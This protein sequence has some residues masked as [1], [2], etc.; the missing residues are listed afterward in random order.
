MEQVARQIN[1]KHVTAAATQKLLV[2]TDPPLAV[3]FQ[4]IISS[5]LITNSARRF[6]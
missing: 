6:N 3:L 4:G 2:F 1:I 5:E